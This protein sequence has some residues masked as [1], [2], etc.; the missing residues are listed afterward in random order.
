MIWDCFISKVM[1]SV[2]LALDV[3]VNLQRKIGSGGEAKIYC[4][5]WLDTPV[6]IKSLNDEVGVGNCSDIQ[7]YNTLRL[8]N[9][10]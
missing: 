8:V 6:A 4:G 3:K 10:Y 5:E 2:F 7:E 9:D 1:I